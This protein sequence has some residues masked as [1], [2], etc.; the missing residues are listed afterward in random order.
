[1]SDVADDVAS[2][3]I[4]SGP[5]GK[6]IITK[7]QIFQAQSKESGG[8]VTQISGYAEYRITSY[9]LV[10]GVQTGRVNM[11]EGIEEAFII[12]GT[13]PGKIW[14][15]SIN[16]EL[17]FHCR[18]PKTLEVIS[19]E[20]ALTANGPLKGFAFARPE[21]MK[22]N[23]QYGWSAQNGNLML[24]DMQGFH[25]YYDPQKN[26]L[27][28]TEDA[29]VDYDWATHRTG[30]NG[31]FT[32][33]E[34]VSLGGNGRQ[35]LMYGYEDSTGKYSYLHGEILIDV[36][37]LH[38]AD[39]KKEALIAIDKE[40]KKINDSISRLRE[41]FPAMGVEG[42][43]YS[44]ISNEEWKAKHISESLIRNKESLERDRKSITREN[45]KYID[46]PALSDAEGNLFIIHATDVSDTSHMQ[47]T[48]VNLDG[49]T[50]NEAWTV[51][52]DN[53]YRDPEKADDKG[54]FET[55]FSEG[56]PSFRYQWFD[57]ADNKLFIISQL[58]M[59]C[60]D[61]KSGKVLWE[62]PL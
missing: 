48:K 7:E 15:F 44:Q 10:T 31:Y 36:N 52:L 14:L 23:Q 38:D 60:L 39:R 42:R 20:K 8:G 22:L 12:M 6:S 9:D 1:M 19:N 46:H 37:P 56:N 51:R 59:I 53:F 30:N 24:S 40:E 16:P 43:S 26:T 17:G 28:K 61:V 18:N 49:R 54:V 33:E 47:V 4:Y 27:E 25:Y 13:S 11:G 32:K 50:F 21:W 5:E 41:L 57:I 2:A 45:S 29:I 55:V 35:K 3:F 62:H 58:R 34:Y